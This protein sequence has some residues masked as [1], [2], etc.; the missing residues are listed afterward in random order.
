MT[1]SKGHGTVVTYFRH[2][3]AFTWKTLKKLIS[4]RTARL[5]AETSEIWNSTH[6]CC[7]VPWHKRPVNYREHNTSWEGNNRSASHHFPR[8]SWDLIH[9]RVHK[10]LSL[11][12]SWHRWLQFTP[13]QPISLRASSYPGFVN[14][15][16]STS[17]VGPKMLN[18]C[19][20]NQCLL[21]HF[22]GLT[23][24]RSIA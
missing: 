15:N 16:K 12:L 4:A 8:L 21:L 1:N 6:H 23:E 5:A 19:K 22:R 13:S 3:L 14:R 9:Q 7:H 11:D 18:L 24:A 2:Y 10:S 17:P 20:L